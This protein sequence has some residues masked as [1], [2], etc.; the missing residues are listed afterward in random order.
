MYFTAEGSTPSRA[1]VSSPP[2]DL[3]PRERSCTSPP[4][5]LLPRERRCPHR[6]RIYSLASGAVLT[7]EASTRSET[8]VGTP[9]L[10]RVWRSKTAATAGQPGSGPGNR[11]LPCTP[12]RSD[13]RLIRPA[14]TPVLTTLGDAGRNRTGDCLFCRQAP[15]HLA[16]APLA[17]V[18]GFEPGSTGLE[19]A[20]LAVVLHPRSF[21]SINC[22][23]A[24]KK[25]R[26][27]RRAFL[28][29][30]LCLDSTRLLCANWPS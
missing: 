5:D 9:P 7:A 21:L 17:G 12:V 27:L 22:Q 24:I 16:T 25:A 29:S 11:T 15:S 26:F 13:Y 3:L 10:Q 19:S 4:K 6:R 1:A 14:R 2:K 8:A 18:P 28:E 30:W 20:R 23:R